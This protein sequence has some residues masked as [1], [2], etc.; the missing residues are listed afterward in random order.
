VRIIDSILERLRSEHDSVREK[1]TIAVGTML[2]PLSHISEQ[3]DHLLHELLMLTE[4]P[5]EPTAFAAAVVFGYHGQASLIAVPKILK[6]LVRSLNRQ[7][8]SVDPLFNSV[9]QIVG[10][11]K[12]YLDQ[13]PSLLSDDAR[14]VIRDELRE[15]Q[16]P[17]LV[18]KRR[19]R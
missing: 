10:D 7:D 1:A 12:S 17:H 18:G 19:R 9:N 2:V 13:N 11:L 6:L 4:G 16:Q 14:E 3:G 15:R 5:H 8:E